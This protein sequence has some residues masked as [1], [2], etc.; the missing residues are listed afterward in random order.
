MMNFQ[1]RVPH[2]PPPPP[3]QQQQQQ[4]QPRGEHDDVLEW[5]LMLWS[6]RAPWLV[7]QMFRW[8]VDVPLRLLYFHGPQIRTLGIG[9]WEGQS[10]EQICAQLTNG[11]TD[12]TFWQH[13]SQSHDQCRDIVQR[14]YQSFVLTILVCLY[15]FIVLR[16]ILKRLL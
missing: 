2:P 8:L 6:K 4:Q 1:N 15:L 16:V 7:Q 12:S 11:Y 3:P 13:S 5:F 14:R 9:F 10:M